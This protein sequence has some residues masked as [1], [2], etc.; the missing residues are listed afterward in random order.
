MLSLVD[1]AG[2]QC[3]AGFGVE[4]LFEP[5][6][7]RLGLAVESKKFQ[8]GF[9]KGGLR[10]AGVSTNVTYTAVGEETLY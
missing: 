6:A 2:K 1:Y 4:G 3:G 7:W 9:L 8:Q 10:G 5:G